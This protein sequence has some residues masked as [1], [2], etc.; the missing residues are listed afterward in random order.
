MQVVLLEDV[1]CGRFGP[2]TLLR[3]EFDLRCGMLELRE[4]LEARR[5][6]WRVALCPRPEL[7]DLVAEH[8]PGRGLETLDDGPALLLY[9]RVVVDEDLLRAVEGLSGEILLMSGGEAVG[10]VLDG[11]VRE[12]IER[13]SVASDGV[14]ALGLSN[15]ADVPAR[16]VRYP[17]DL[18]AATPAEI[19]ADAAIAAELGQVKVELHHCARL[20]GEGNVAVGEGSEIGPSVV[21]DAREGPV[22]IGQD[23]TVMP[24]AV[25]VGPAFVGDGSV[26]R[27]CA[28]VYGGTS[29]GPVCKVGGE[30]A[31][32]VL[33]SHSNKQHGGF[34]GHSFVGSWVNL[35]AATNNSDLKN[36][37]GTVRVEI[38]GEVVD[39]GSISVGAVIGDHSKTAIGTRLNTGTVVGIFCSVYATGF[40]PK[41]IPS[42]SWGTTDGFVRHELA[43]ALDTA[44]RAMERRGERMTPALERR[45]RDLHEG[46]G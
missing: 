40:P 18:V 33:Q 37:Y 36:N 38:E 10:A 25:I 19:A 8:R 24:N 39:T 5:P 2:L 30:V 27:A 9:G 14:G 32:S 13:H 26:V 7:A 29:I 23:V 22:V 41:S 45:I 11:D 43:Q 21:L 20:L 1:A 35:G 4:K 3:P 42:F 46:T 6:D 34:L 28:S 16:V 15:T 44:A 31:E 17:W 12:R